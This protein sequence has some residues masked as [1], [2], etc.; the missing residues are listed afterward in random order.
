MSR[1]Q[2][3]IADDDGLIRQM[4][5]EI[6]DEQLEVT[7]DV[8]ATA[9][10]AVEKAAAT[11]YD[12][13]LLDIHFPDCN[14]LTTL[15]RIRTA[16]PNTDVII[17]T[18]QVDDLQIVREATRHGI[19]DYI[20]KPLRPEDIAIRVTRALE[21]R[22]LKHAYEHAIAELSAGWEFDDIIGQSAQMQSILKQA[23]QISSN[24][25]PVLVIGE[26]GTGKELIARAIHYAS[27]R[28]HLPF[29]TINC[30]AIAPTLLE[31]ELF[32]HE[33]GSFTGATTKRSGVFARAGSGSL[34][35]DEIGDIRPEG[36]AALLRV[37]EQKEY[38]P[39]GGQTQTTDA[40][41]ILATNQD[42]DTLVSEGK[43]R[44]DLFY[45]IDRLRINLPPLR[46]RKDDIPLLARF[47]LTQIESKIAKGITQ[48]P[49]AIITALQSYDWPGNVRELRNEIERAYIQ[50][51]GHS[52]QIST[53]SPQVL[54]SAAADENED[55]NIATESIDELQRLLDALRAADGN[56]SEAARILNVHRNTVHR[57]MNKYQ[58][59]DNT[60][61]G[62]QEG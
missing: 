59:G 22:C 13:V 39:V 32:G 30:A 57:W 28:R 26:T 16:A 31:A 60:T 2:I 23:G 52:L 24:D 37:L 51:T 7:T 11:S 62:E 1:P 44:K 25:F 48:I 27:P 36:Q 10:E 53:L 40:R 43:F 50:S 49:D 45:R 4:L 18:S 58:L 46:Q 41:I 20:P 38:T 35:L 29:V 6:L 19:F 47:F 55:S 8:A 12:L 5:R 15:Q 56:V 61:D 54:V 33:K 17:V 9:A 3:L 21:M 34:F 14:D 42:L